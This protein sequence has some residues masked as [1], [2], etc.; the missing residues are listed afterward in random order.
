MLVVNC[1]LPPAVFAETAIA[2]A[3]SPSAEIPLMAA[4]E[5]AS[6]EPDSA[7][8]TSTEPIST[9]LT[10]A[11]SGGE[12]SAIAMAEPVFG[13]S[14][15]DFSSQY[16]ALTKQVLLNG[17]EMERYSLKFRLE[18]GRQ[19]RTRRERFFA[20][21]ETGAAC[22]LAFEIVGDQ[23]LGR[24]RKHLLQVNKQSLHGALA[25]VMTGSIIAGSGSA[26]EL[27]ANLLQAVKNKH[28]GYDHASARKYVSAKLKFIDQLLAQ[29]DALVAANSSS[30][31]Y[32]RA[33]V[34]GQILHEMRNCFISEF[35]Q[36]STDTRSYIAFQNSF[37]L[38]N[39]AYNA[40]GALGAY[41]GYKGVQS[42]RY[43]GQA[44]ILFIVSGG[45]AT[46]APLVSTAYGKLMA[47]LERSA[48]VR[49]IG[50]KPVFDPA[51]MD[52][53]CKKMQTLTDE[54]EGTLTPSLPATKRI[55]F[56]TQ[57]EDAFARQLQSETVVMRKLEKVVLQ[58]NLLG[59]VI[60]GQLMTQGILGTAGYY[61]YTFKPRKQLAFGYYGSVVG[62]VGTSMAVVGN[63][64]WF[65]SSLSYV[66]RLSREKRL[67]V[68]LIK[69]RL[70]HLDEIE[71]TVSTM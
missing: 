15:S 22:G 45:L 69:S 8:L 50:E 61:K 16:T 58:N 14:S 23:Q 31:A 26:M 53:L 59:P 27:G 2:A 60:G 38:F 36:F 3:A 33:L 57:A 49:A 63:A 41:Y 62:T 68:Q 20:A 52:A 55:A 35:S 6:T 7:K 4:T 67:P 34:E 5:P 25:T 13:S 65:L 1:S 11:Q 44:N 12:K 28:N 17:I 30:P 18:S 48:L 43:N 21:Q 54:S 47:Q 56:Y 64:A 42:P 24:G 51:K 32:E 9:E 70:E 66:N 39:A 46:V 19:P 37:F 40:L 29:R 71:K 10:S